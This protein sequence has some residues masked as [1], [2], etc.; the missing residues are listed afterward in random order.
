M[1][2]PAGHPHGLIE[3]KL[4][5]LLEPFIRDRQIG[6]Y[7]GSSQGFELPSGD[8]V[9]PDHSFVSTER[10][11]AMPP[12]QEGGFLRV[13]PDLVVEI[14]SPSTASHDRGEKRAIYEHNGVREYWLVDSRAREVAVF[15]LC[16]DRFD[17]GRVY[18]EGAVLRSGVLSG[19]EIDI[20][21][22]LPRST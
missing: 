20:Q 3:G 12:P 11:Q 6:V 9:A 7:L 4:A 22:I 15:T 17:P 19:L 16:G 13:V 1:T 18:P 21:S 8:T 14:L 10:W 2:P 5:G